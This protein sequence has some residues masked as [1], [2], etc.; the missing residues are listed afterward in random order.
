MSSVVTIEEVK[1]GFRNPHTGYYYGYEAYK[2][3]ELARV[4]KDPYYWNDFSRSAKQYRLQFSIYDQNGNH[5]ITKMIT[6]VAQSSTG[7]ENIAFDSLYSDIYLY[8]SD[9]WSNFKK[10]QW[11]WDLYD[12]SGN[13]LKTSS[14]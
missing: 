9:I 1:M 12:D 13:F 2:A 3:S 11:S 5:F 4:R 10:Y 14:K 7:A 8:H 6:L